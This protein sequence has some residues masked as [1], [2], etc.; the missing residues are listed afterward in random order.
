M[1]RCLSDKA[2]MRLVAELG[3]A[4]ERSHVATCAACAARQRR[5]GHDLD[6]IR[7]VLLTTSE[8]PRHVTQSRRWSVVGVTG[9][10]AVAVAALVWIEVAVWNTIQPAE[11]PA[12]TEQV[13]AA[14]EDVTAALFSVDGEPTR[15]LADASTMNAL[16][17]ESARSVGCEEPR[18]LD[19][20]ECSDTLFSTEGSE[21]GI[22][23]DTPERTVF[24]TESADQGG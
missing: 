12:S 20:A 13:E 18:W 15:S 16:E 9:L 6:R 19:E 11:D 14:L 23:M 8:P 3:T 24:D 21:D 22:E 2:L 4:A 10:A 1:S 17:P 7:Q 5:V